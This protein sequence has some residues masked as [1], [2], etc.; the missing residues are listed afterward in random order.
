MERIGTADFP[1]IEIQQAGFLPDNDSQSLAQLMAGH[2][3]GGRIVYVAQQGLEFFSHL[4]G[5]IGFLRAFRRKGGSQ[6]V[7]I[8]MTLAETIQEGRPSDR[9]QGEKDL[10]YLPTGQGHQQKD[11]RR[12]APCYTDDKENA[13]QYFLWRVE[14]PGHTVS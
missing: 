14:F 11:A 8:E 7:K 5:D 10:A 4:P 2:P 9:Q 6:S 13:V 12:Q 1:A 3:V